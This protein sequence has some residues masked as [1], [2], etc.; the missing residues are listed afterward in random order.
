MYEN[1]KQYTENQLLILY[2]L[3]EIDIPIPGMQLTDVMLEPRL[4]NYFAMQSALCDLIDSGMV[5]SAK[6]SGGIPLYSCTK[7]GLEVL[8]SLSDILPQAIIDTYKSYLS[9]EKDNIRK[10]AEVNANYFTTPDGNYYCRCFIREGNTYIAD[11]RI[12]AADKSEAIEICKNW[13]E[14]TSSVYIKVIKAMLP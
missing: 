9:K 6:D 4:M 13:K 1:E 5:K 3:K 14:N 11:V 8:S 2:V 7:K 12:P 10:S